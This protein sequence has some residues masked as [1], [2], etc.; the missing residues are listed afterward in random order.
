METRNILNSWLHAKVAISLAQNIVNTFLFSEEQLSCLNVL[1]YW[2]K[3]SFL[4]I[5]TTHLQCAHNRHLAAYTMYAL[6]HRI[7]ANNAKSLR[8]FWWVNVCTRK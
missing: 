5:A 6:H 8:H 1:L 2:H 3:Q 4:A 7:T